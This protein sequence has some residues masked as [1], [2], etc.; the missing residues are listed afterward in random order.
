MADRNLSKRTL[1]FRRPTRSE[2]TE[3][4]AVSIRSYG[5]DD[6]AEQLAHEV[7]SNEID[8]SF[9]AW[10]GDQCVGGSGAFSLDVTLPGGRIAP[11]AGV[12]MIGV[13]P[14]HRRRGILTTMLGQLHAD[15]VER[16]EPIA[17]LTATEAS[18]Y[19][20]FGYGMAAEVAH[21]SI[22]A[23]K[24]RFEPAV[25]APGTFALVDPHRDMHVLQA[26]HEALRTQ[27]VGSL[28]LTPGMWAQLQA[29][30][31]WDRV[32][33]S[34]LRAVVHRDDAGIPD[35]F[36]TWR[37]RP[38]HASDRIAGNTVCLA[39]LAGANPEIEAALWEFVASIDL[40]TCVEWETGPV[41]PT[42]RWRLIEPR[43]LRTRARADMVW[44]RLLDI[45]KALSMRS[46]GATGS[47]AL[48]V[49]DPFH[50]ENAGHYLIRASG[51][52]QGATCTRL[53][54]VPTAPTLTIDTADLASITMGAVTP[55]TLAA[56]GRIA[57]STATIAMADA[58]FANTKAPHWPIE[59]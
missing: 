6:T 8:R 35:G 20:R 29:D 37:I 16:D 39:M 42:I 30:P 53:D 56:A 28:R 12:T 25:A 45:P 10:D 5:G 1:A 36:A 22:A 24:V 27:H 13:E 48:H 41:D 34:P 47:L 55:A 50:P 58:F 52:S 33:V 15:G 57:G 26:T 4:L 40:A 59:F 44:A 14:T 46:Y 11:A 43:Q 49:H 7:L 2:I 18:I 9:G 19:R 51:Q 31:E 32:G 23:D 17:L 38:R 54:D 21:L 3:F